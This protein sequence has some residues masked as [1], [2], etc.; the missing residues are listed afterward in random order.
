MLERTF[1]K[2]LPDGIFKNFQKV[3][4]MPVMKLFLPFYKTIVNIFFETTKRTPGMNMLMPSVRK[5][6]FGNN[7]EAAR[8]MAYARTVTGFGFMAVTAPF[9]YT[10]GDFADGKQFIITGIY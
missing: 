4:N 9:V 10:P 1:Q 3:A 5:D 2:E 8:Q 7:G 6:L